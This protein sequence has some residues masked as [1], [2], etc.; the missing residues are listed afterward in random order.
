[1]CRDDDPHHGRQMPLLRRSLRQ[2]QKG[3]KKKKSKKQDAGLIYEGS[4]PTSEIVI[5]VL[6]S[7]NRLVS[8][9]IVWG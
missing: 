8:A 2:R 1:M 9:G 6:C 5:R 7:G 4:S 3:E